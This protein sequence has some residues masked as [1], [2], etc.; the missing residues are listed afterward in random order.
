MDYLC[1]VAGVDVLALV[2]ELGQALVSRNDL[3]VCDCRPVRYQ[4]LVGLAW[5]RIVA[6]FTF[7]FIAVLFNEYNISNVLIMNSRMDKEFLLIEID[8]CWHRPIRQTCSIQNASHDQQGWVN[9]MSTQELKPSGILALGILERNRLQS[10][11]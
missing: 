5:S 11:D 6:R 9:E 1:I 3:V 7:C 8:E 10:L 4:L 2:Y